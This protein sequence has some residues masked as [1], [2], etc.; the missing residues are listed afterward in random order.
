MSDQINSFISPITNEVVEQIDKLNLT[1]IQKLHLKLLAHCLESFKSI[2]GLSSKDIPN[3]QALRDW[4][5]SEADKLKDKNFAILLFEQMEAAAKKL[6][7]YS[8]QIQ[9]QPLE[10]TLEDLITLVSLLH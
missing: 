8:K 3:K 2:A 5:D 1:T 4:C 10:L 9:K 6:E 7:K